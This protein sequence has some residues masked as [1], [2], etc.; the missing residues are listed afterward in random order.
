[1]NNRAIANKAR[2]NELENNESVSSRTIL[3]CP[4]AG[5]YMSDNK[6]ENTVTFDMYF[7]FLL[8]FIMLFSIQVMIV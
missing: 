4:M 3:S 7:L 1:N 8:L 2:N 6:V 5:K